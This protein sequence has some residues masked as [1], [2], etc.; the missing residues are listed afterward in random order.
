MCVRSERTTSAA[1]I[2]K[3]MDFFVTLGRRARDEIDRVI[4]NPGRSD[5]GNG[6]DGT[7]TTSSE[8]YEPPDLATLFCVNDHKTPPEIRPTLQHQTSLPEP[9]LSHHDHTDR[10]WIGNGL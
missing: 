8:R 7:A 1:T 2:R 3:S 9:T 4:R 5:I 10:F 6:T